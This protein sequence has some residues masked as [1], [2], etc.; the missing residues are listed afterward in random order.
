MHGKRLRLFK[1]SF[2]I[3]HDCYNSFIFSQ[4]NYHITVTNRPLSTVHRLCFSTCREKAFKKR[5]V[6]DKLM[7]SE[8]HLMW[9]QLSNWEKQTWASFIGGFTKDHSDPG[10]QRSWKSV[11]QHIKTGLPLAHELKITVKREARKQL[12]YP[13]RN[14]RCNVAEVKKLF[15]QV[16]R[17]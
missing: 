3:N 11:S 17:V 10:S 16:T 15:S 7:L 2:Y 5:S 1:T 13:A 9:C 6:S 14:V 12:T 8:T 4:N